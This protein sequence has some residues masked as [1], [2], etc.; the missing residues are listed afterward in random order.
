MQVQVSAP[1]YVYVVNEDERGDSYLLFPLPGQ[2]VLNPLTP[3]ERHRLP[4]TVDG[5]SISWAVTSTGERE[6]FLIVASPTRSTEFDEL[7]ATLPRP[8]FGKPLA[9]ARLTPRAMAVLLRSVGGLAVSAAQID[10]QLRAMPE[11][12][13]A[14]TD[15]EETARGIWLRHATFANPQ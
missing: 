12:S 3:G 7:F 2:G 15:S 13:T 1:T 10:R 6:H 8:R 4:G 9:N 5:E 14:L 11:F